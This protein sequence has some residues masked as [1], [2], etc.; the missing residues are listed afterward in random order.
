MHSA[1]YEG[2]VR[3]RRFTP[4]PHAFR[5]AVSMAYLDLDE[6]DTVFGK[7]WF[8]STKEF[9][10]V[11]FRRD[12]YMIGSR[13]PGQ[14]L[15]DAVRDFVESRTSSRPCG[16]VRILTNLRCFGFG[17][18]PVSFYYCFNPDG[19]SLH[20]IVAEITNTPWGEQFAY[21][22][23]CHSRGGDLERG[24][25][26]DKTQPFQPCVECLPTSTS[27]LHRFR[28]EKTFHVSPFMDMGFEYDWR[29]TIPADRL[30][31][32]MLNLKPS[33]R[34]FDSTMLLSRREISTGSLASALA[35][36][37]LMTMKICAAIYFHAAR[38]WIKRCPV[39]AHPRLPKMESPA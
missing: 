28:F 24:R 18:N 8:W 17:M 19:E 26:G 20:S 12:D 2:W 23:P 14:S 9:N 31:V 34:V 35:R 10:F 22:L 1:L 7:R 3:H 39:A 16:P 6:L 11:W 38:L 5:Y 30:A 21:V 27:S 25:G 33:G 15:A 29:F 37:P 36:F 32:H 13:R 4:T